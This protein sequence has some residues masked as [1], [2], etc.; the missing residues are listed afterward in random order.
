MREILKYIILIAAIA[1]IISG[2]RAGGNVSADIGDN[3]AEARKSRYYYFEG[4]RQNLS[5]NPDAAYECYKRAVALDSTNKEA[6]YQLAVTRMDIMDMNLRTPAEIMNNL[7]RMRLFVDE[8]PDDGNENLIYGYMAALHDTTGEGIRVLERLA[9]RQP[10]NTATLIYL[11][12]AYA[13]EGEPE[14]AVE[15]MNRYER[16][17]GVNPT[18]TMHKMSLYMEAGD[19]TGAIREADRLILHDPRNYKSMILKGN[20]QEVI[21]QPDSAEY[22][23]MEAERLAPESSEPKIALMDIYRM[24]G[25]S[26]AYDAKVYEVLLTEDMEVAA[27]TQ[28]LADYLQKLFDNN[29]DTSRG[30]YLFKVLES[31]YPHD[32]DVLDLAARYSYAKGDKEDAIEKVSYALDLNS[33]NRD[34]WQK[35]IYYQGG[36]EK[37]KDAIET[38]LR[39]DSEGMADRNMRLYAAS[40]YHADKQYKSARDV[41][42]KL[43]ADIDPGLNPDTLI[44]LQDVRRDISVEDLDFLSY[45][46]TSMGDSSYSAADTTA[47]FRDYEN[48]LTLN[49]DNALAANNYAY[50]SVE[51]GGDLD[52]AEQLSRKSLTGENAD[53]PTH[54]DTYAWILFL[55]GDLDKAIEIQMRTVKEMEASGRTDAVIYDHYADMLEK[56]GFSAEALKYRQL[57][58]KAEPDNKDFQEK[59]ENAEKGEK[60]RKK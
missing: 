9:E 36:A 2:L 11:S 15:A 43:I 53:N 1:G 29:N 38:Y 35:L 50:F 19:T 20:L 60:Q 31:Q 54:L 12:Q 32:A 5:G 21:N 58:V 8:Y 34:L 59:L 49:S 3:G 57:A 22:Y 55:K 33:R 7:K 4:L 25:D 28:L 39:A 44:S 56:K 52:H 46:F 6:Q 14:K 13:Q 17:E 24:K 16:A 27:K 23:Y 10:D 47:T 41:Y 18:L 26:V 48:A 37:Y 51:M 42:K 45:V 40:L 30:D